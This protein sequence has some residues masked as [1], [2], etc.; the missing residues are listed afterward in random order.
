MTPTLVDT[1][2]HLD[3]KYYPGG[4]DDALSRALE[5]GVVG[6]VAIGVG[7]TLGPAREALAIAAR[8][9]DVWAAVGIHRADSKR[10]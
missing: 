5:A 4:C 3:S 10:L 9:P 7:D 6:F 2:C 1:H 8:R